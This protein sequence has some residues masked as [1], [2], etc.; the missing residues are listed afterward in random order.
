M[1]F[2][3]SNK[4]AKI[5]QTR[6]QKD[7]ILG[8]LKLTNIMYFIKSLQITWIRRL[9]QNTSS[10]WSQLFISTICDPKRLIELGP[11]YSQT[12]SNIILNPFWK[13]VLKYWNTFN[14]SQSQVDFNSNTE[15][16]LHQ[17]LWYNQTPPMV[18]LFIKEWYSKGIIVTGDIFTE[19]NTFHTAEYLHQ[20]FKIKLPD[21]LTFH[22]IKLSVKHNFIQNQTQIQRPYIPIYAK[23]LLKDKKG[24]KNI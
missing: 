6:L 23:T 8:G 17:P 9:V 14:I 5:K 15:K 2:L 22:R 10:P 16:I 20:N 18:Q 7:L 21:Y 11:M 24:I 1:S 3:W 19:N 4:P 12:L 13:G